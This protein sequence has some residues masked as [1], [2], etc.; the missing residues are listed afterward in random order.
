MRIG[1]CCRGHQ[2]IGRGKDHQEWGQSEEFIKEWGRGKG[3]QGMGQGK[4][5]SRKG[6]GEEVI[7]E[8]GRVKRSSRKRGR[9][10]RTS[11]KVAG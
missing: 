9:V 6:A 10:K 1:A 8:G 5:S 3:H 2:G 11:R 7:K 4:R